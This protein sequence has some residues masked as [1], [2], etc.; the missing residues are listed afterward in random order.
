MTTAQRAERPTIRIG[1]GNGHNKGSLVEF[2]KSADC[3][4]FSCNE[5][6]QLLP[7]LRRIRSHRVTAPGKDWVDRRARSTS[8]VTRSAFPAIGEL[9]RQVSENI[10][11][12]EKF[13]PDRVLVA[14]FYEHPVARALGRDGIAHFA[15]HPD[16]TVK[17]R[18]ADHPLVREYREALVSTR[19]WMQTAE[20]DGLLPILTGDLQ[21]S[22][23]ATQDWSPTKLIAD[24]M[25]LKARAVGIDWI[26]IDRRLDFAGP[27][28]KHKLYDHTGFVA[29]L[30]P[31]PRK[32]AS[33]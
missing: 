26:L 11:E 6:D 10:P 5:A 18:R 4:S 20:R 8:L 12:H 16:A 19:K 22:L 33:R 29:T 1:H 25:K 24:P 31:A 9:T 14:S 21:L 32:T 30:A 27:L 17:N 2:V 7:E 15:L 23:R 13:A 3:A 28:H